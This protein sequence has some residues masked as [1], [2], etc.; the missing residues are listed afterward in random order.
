MRNT[1]IRQPVVR[2][3]RIVAASAVVCT[4]VSAGAQTLETTAKDRRD[5]IVTVYNDNKGLVR[6]VRSVQ[7]P[8]GRFELKFADVADKIV[9]PSVHIVSRTDARA[10]D[11]IEQNYK[12]DVLTPSRLMERAVGTDVTF[13][14]E[15]PATGAETR[16][17]ATLLANERGAVYKV[18]NEIV[19]GN[20][21]R[22]VFSQLPPSFV[23]RPTLVWSL[24][25]RAAARAHDLETAY[26]TG[27]MS[28]QADYVA[29]LS[30]DDKRSSLNGWVTIDNQ[31][32]AAFD[33]ARLALVAGNVHSVGEGDDEAYRPGQARARG[34]GGAF[35]EESLLDYH[36]YTLGRVTDIRDKEQKQIALMTAGDV[37]VVKVLR[38]VGTPSLQGSPDALQENLHPAV[39]LEFRNDAASKLGMALPMGTVR[40]YK[41]DQAG[42]QQF[43]GEDRI[44]H[45]P[46]GE[47]V[48]LRLGEAFDVVAE[49]KSVDFKVLSKD[50]VEATYE[51][52]VKNHKEAEVSVQV[53]EH[54]SGQWELLEATPTRGEKLDARRQRFTVKV[55]SRGEVVVRYKVR[56]RFD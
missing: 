40:V 13:V 8:A 46:N 1:M 38:L 12:F 18:G 41:A 19:I 14:R 4:T 26:V 51:V 15:N 34:Q 42:G 35:S 10:V 56:A 43:L 44:Q 54:F 21:G 11:V 53:D 3:L 36:L 52:K 47:K 55:P 31:S 27:G 33:R 22:P 23:A 30:A 20:L 29:V 49:R 6:E 39:F 45:T 24:E 37:P 9:A 48:S 16:V 50:L 2:T 5:V 25:N 7:L 28:W 32:G 17:T